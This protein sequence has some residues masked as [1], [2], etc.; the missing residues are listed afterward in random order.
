MA[1]NKKACKSMFCRLNLICFYLKKRLS[2]ESEGFEPSIPFRV[3]TLSRRAPSTTRTTLHYF[4]SFET[5]DTLSVFTISPGLW[6]GLLQRPIPIGRQRFIFTGC[7]NTFTM[8]SSR[9]FLPLILNLQIP[10]LQST[11]CFSTGR[12]S[13]SCISNLKAL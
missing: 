10:Y 5:I 9:I 2:A 6:S 4:L 11:A 1:K 7:K 8:L 12:Y 3:Y 13:C